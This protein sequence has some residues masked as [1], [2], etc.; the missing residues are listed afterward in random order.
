M[1]KNLLK[2]YKDKYGNNLS[3]SN[4]IKK[5]NSYNRVEEIYNYN[6]SRIEYKDKTLFDY[7]RSDINSVNNTNKN[8]FSFRDS[9]SKT[10][11]TK[12]KEKN[13]DNNNKNKKK[14]EKRVSC[15]YQTTNKLQ[16]KIYSYLNNKENN[17]IPFINPNGNDN[18][19][20]NNIKNNR[21]Q[22]F[23]DNKNSFSPPITKSINI[24]GSIE[25]NSNNFICHQNPIFYN[26]KNNFH[27]FGN[28]FYQNNNLVVGKY[29]DNS[30][31][32]FKSPKQE[33]N[34]QLTKTISLLKEKIISNNNIS[35]NS[36]TTKI[37]GLTKI[38]F[39]FFCKRNF[40]ENIKINFLS[41]NI[42]GE[43]LCEPPY[44]FI[45]SSIA[46][47][48]SYDGLRIVPSTLLDPL[49]F[50][51]EDI[52][53]T[54]VSSKTKKI[55]EIYRNFKKYGKTMKKSEFINK[56]KEEY[57]NM[58]E[59]EIEKCLDYKYFGFE[60]IAKG[61]KLELIMN[62]YED[63]KMWINGLA[64]II[65]NKKELIEFVKHLKK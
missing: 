19:Y 6:S 57:K 51:I 15:D 4:K 44:N 61:Q 3:F 8:R 30:T 16:E 29:I 9:K 59:E 35:Y 25:N 37:S 56:E 46:M 39:C 33:S 7:F 23:F 60:L 40:N 42:N 14:R 17:K 32:L 47:N 5:D 41:N 1:I 18:I 11:T 64:F 63:F 34:L 20:N 65:K 21:F 62:S 22:N 58:S 13:N 10:N 49:D 50:S 55:V 38:T 36:L 12:N 24:L 43:N 48:K 28:N 52:E 53:N 45:R 2:N 31:N 54:V 26:S 27:S